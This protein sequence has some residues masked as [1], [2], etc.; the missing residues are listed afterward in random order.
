MTKELKSSVVTL[1]TNA[2]EASV[3]M[4]QE[5]KSME[6]NMKIDHSKLVSYIVADYKENYFH[7]NKKKIAN[8]HRDSKKQ[9]KSKISDLTQE[10]LENLSKY[11]ERMQPKVKTESHT[12]D[13]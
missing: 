7:K 2:K 11:I 9:L 13:F 4:L 10:Q 8:F 12:N 1:K 3:S 5:L 6:L